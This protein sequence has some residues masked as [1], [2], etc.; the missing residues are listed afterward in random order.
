VFDDQVDQL[1]A[2]EPDFV[3]GERFSFLGRSYPLKVVPRMSDHLRFEGSRFI[4]RKNDRARALDHFRNWYIETGR[5]WLQERATILGRRTATGASN[6]DVRELGFRWGSCGKHSTLYF[7][8]RM[9]QLPVRLI[10]YVIVHE[11][12][13][14]RHQ[15]HAPD[16]WLAVERAMPDWKARREEL[17]RPAARY[18]VFDQPRLEGKEEATYTVRFKAVA[19]L[20]MHM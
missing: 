1:V 3:S 12:V 18:L 20:S 11:L 13:H 6:I 8:W 19:R 9:L 16:F 2:V 14:L 15:H 4:L 7:N 5:G 10:D 17:Q